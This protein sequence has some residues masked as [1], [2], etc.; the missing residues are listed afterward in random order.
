[1]PIGICKGCHPSITVV[2]IMRTPSLVVV[3][4]LCLFYKVSFIIICIIDLCSAIIPHM[5]A[6]PC[7]I[8]CIRYHKPVCMLFFKQM[9]IFI[10][11]APCHISIPV[12]LPDNIF[13]NIIGTFLCRS[14]LISCTDKLAAAV[15]SVAHFPS[16]P[17]CQIGICPFIIIVEH[18]ILLPII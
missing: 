4:L 10:I 9:S 12:L 8:I 2:R 1:M 5:A 16:T 13:P 6:I 17:W 18:N 11:G 7:C 3:Y 15:I 14:I